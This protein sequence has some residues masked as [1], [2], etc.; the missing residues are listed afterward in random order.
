MAQ[1]VRHCEQNLQADIKRPKDTEEA[2]RS[3]L[4]LDQIPNFG[5]GKLKKF[6]HVYNLSADSLLTYS[7]SQLAD[8]GFDSAQV[9]AI[10]AP[11]LRLVDKEL[12][13]LAAERSRFAV[14]PE[15]PDFPFLLSEIAR[16]PL[17]L[18]GWGNKN[19]LASNQI[20]MVGSRNPSHYGRNCGFDIASGLA[21]HGI[22]ITS[23]LA[24]GID[25][26]AHQGALSAGGNTLAVLGSGLDNLYPKRNV[27]LAHD[28]I[29]NEG[30]ILSEFRASTK[31]TPHNF[32]RRNRIVSGLSLGVLVIEAA[33]KSGSLI[34]AKYAIEQNREVFAIPGN[35]NNPL[36]EG[37]HLLIKQGAKLVSSLQD[38]I[39][40]FQNV[41]SCVLTEYSK[42]SEK[43]PIESLATDKLLD[44]VDHDVTALDVVIQRSEMPIKVVLAQLLEY[45]LRGLVASVSGGYIKLR[46]K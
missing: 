26:C 9:Q 37:A 10:T 38:I 14:Y 28:I 18:F 35:I 21:S 30:V 12:N 33:I 15:H 3:W 31:P 44:S 29:Q 40:E 42:N 2:L 7:K 39:E 13:W 32:P 8:L 25:A 36:S 4:I 43:S 24:M 46:G 20:A 5:M 41:N 17:I 27:K 6:Q 1:E 34:T 22:T 11:D 23:G 45:E 16:P 19:L